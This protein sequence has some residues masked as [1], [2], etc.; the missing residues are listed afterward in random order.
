[1][2]VC[3]F[4]S[5]AD[6][7]RFILG[8]EVGARG[9]QRRGFGSPKR[10]VEFF[11]PCLS[12]RRESREGLMLWWREKGVVC[13]SR[14]QIH[15][16]FHI[17]VVSSRARALRRS[18]KSKCHFVAKRTAR[19]AR[20]EFMGVYFWKERGLG[21]DGCVRHFLDYARTAVALPPPPNSPSQPF[22]YMELVR[23]AF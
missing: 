13:P 18:R 14:A 11:P 6:R 23:L 16:L 15:V 21:T 17:H 4:A 9:A 8:V 3:V 7:N 22:V 19:C 2:C 10:A 20:L 1:M 5:R 12:E